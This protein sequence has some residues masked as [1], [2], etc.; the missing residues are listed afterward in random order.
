MQEGLAHVTGEYLT[1]VVCGASYAHLEDIGD[2][3]WPCVESGQVITEGLVC[4]GGVSWEIDEN[5]I[6]SALS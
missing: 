2:I 4:G 3:I 1:T 5:F 6:Y